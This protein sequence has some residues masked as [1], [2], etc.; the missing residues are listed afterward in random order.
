MPDVAITLSELADAL[1]PGNARALKGGALDGEQVWFTY[2]TQQDDHVRPSHAALNGTVWRVGDPNAPIPPIDFGCRCF[3][4]FCAKPGSPAAKIL[5]TAQAE[6]T[7]QAEVWSAYLDENVE[8]WR[9]MM[10]GLYA[11]VL[12]DRI[13]SLALRIQAK[14]GKM[15]A[16]SRELARMAL[17]V[18]PPTSEGAT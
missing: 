12:P 14:T 1:T 9:D 10:R 11:M 8:G 2:R 4:S 3:S 7:T 5:P 6:P 13:N 16:D 15:L 18:S 17:S